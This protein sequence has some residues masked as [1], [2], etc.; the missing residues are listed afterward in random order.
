MKEKDVLLNPP[1]IL[2]VLLLFPKPAYEVLVMVDFDFGMV[3]TDVR[4]TPL[5]FRELLSP[6]KGMVLLSGIC[7][8]GDQNL[9][10]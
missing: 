10:G 4:G 8:G 5:S 3:S 9:S 2:L 6:F 1:D 7:T